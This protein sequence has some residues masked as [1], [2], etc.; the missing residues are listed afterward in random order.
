M[1]VRQALFRRFR[2]LVLY[3][4][5]LFI[6][7]KDGHLIMTGVVPTNPRGWAKDG[8]IVPRIFDLSLLAEKGIERDVT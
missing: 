8:R 1:K 6:R 7:E 5:S 4:S 2:F 3:K